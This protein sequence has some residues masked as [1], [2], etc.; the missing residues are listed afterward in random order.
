M[1]YF[2]FFQLSTLI[3]EEHNELIPVFVSVFVFVFKTGRNVNAQSMAI[4][5]IPD[6]MRKHIANYN[7]IYCTYRYIL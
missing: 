4:A 7:K 3:M 5:I 2:G 1:T 6:N